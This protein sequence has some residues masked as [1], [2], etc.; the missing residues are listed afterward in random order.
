MGKWRTSRIYYY[1]TISCLQIMQL[2]K[3]T[4]V[5]IIFSPSWFTGTSDNG[6]RISKKFLE[7]YVCRMMSKLYFQSTID[8]EFKLAVNSYIEKT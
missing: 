6:T 8:K 7:F 3:N 2:E 4:K 5:V 1:I